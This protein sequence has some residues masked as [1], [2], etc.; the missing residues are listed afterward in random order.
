MQKL[1]FPPLLTAGFH[2]FDDDGL[3][4]LCVDSLPKSL[5]RNDLCC[6]YIQYMKFIRDI[7][8]QIKCF[9]EVWIDG[10]F[11]TEK[12]EPDDI[13]LLLV[14]DY[15]A[16]NQLPST[17][18]G[19]VGAMLDRQYVK[20]NFDIDVLLLAENHPQVNYSERRSYWRG[21]FGFDRKENPKGLVR[22]ML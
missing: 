15:Q 3:K 2:D 9:S 4:R 7:N 6:K 11:S 5:R 14:L 13:D 1:C 19:Q 12:P 17:L 20:Q 16:L 22:I 10:S 18:H 21:W 8:L